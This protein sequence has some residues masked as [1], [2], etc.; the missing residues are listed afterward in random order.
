MA[1]KSGAHR[2]LLTDTGKHEALTFPGPGAY[3]SFKRASIGSLGEKYTMRM[4]TTVPGNRLRTPG[5][6]TYNPKEQM[7]SVGKY[8]ISKYQSSGAMKMPQA[9]DH[10]SSSFDTPGPGAY[11]PKTSM[12]KTGQYFITFLKNSGSR[13]FG[14]AARK[15]FPG[16]K[17]GT[18]Y[19][20]TPGPGAYRHTSEFG[21][22]E[23]VVARSTR[24]S[25]TSINGKR[26]TSPS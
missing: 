17:E 18:A 26:D 11:E 4:K 10:L 19:A 22:Y 2:G 21:L 23:H 9:E 16:V 12:T 24:P 5:P 14:R 15:G 25:T 1:W 7:D 13:S 6:G 20:D 8:S 3:D